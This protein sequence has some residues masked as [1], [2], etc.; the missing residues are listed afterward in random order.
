MAIAHVREVCR[1]DCDRLKN[2]LK[3]THINCI[4][5]ALGRPRPAVG[6][7]HDTGKKTIKKNLTI[8]E[9]KRVKT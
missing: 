4:K 9:D 3:S 7:A 1:D 6:K 2:S 8:F 5:T